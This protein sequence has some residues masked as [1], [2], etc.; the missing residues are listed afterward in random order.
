MVT[1]MNRFSAQSSRTCLPVIV[2]LMLGMNVRSA[3]AAEI[4]LLGAGPLRAVLAALAEQFQRETG[5][6]VKI[7]NVPGAEVTKILASDEPA[8]IYLGS[9]TA[10]DALVK[11]GKTSG[12]KAL[13]G[14]LGI[15]IMVRQD[16]PVPAVST[17]AEI[18]AAV[19]GASAVA[20][21]TAPSGQYVQKIFEQM[22]VADQ[23]KDKSVRPPNG[24]QTMERMVRGTGPEIGFGLRNEMTPFLDKGLHFVAMLPADLQNY[25]NV[26]G[27]VLSRTKSADAAAAFLRF[28]GGP[29]ARP[30]FAKAGFD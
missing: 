23:I 16:A 20:Y 24:V 29:A 2:A 5:H 18:K 9:A 17:A 6:V 15:G 28:I 11:D 8:D 21:N 4:R 1:L 25:N 10:I 7:D 30:L 26:E 22:G 14:R 27:I 13:V 3:S 19:L 12:Q